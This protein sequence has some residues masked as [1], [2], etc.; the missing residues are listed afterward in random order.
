MKP[1]VQL[2]PV[3]LG[4]A[5][6]RFATLH[7]AEF[8]IKNKIGIGA[9]V[10]LIRS[11]DVIP[12][13]QKVIKPAREGKMPDEGYNYQWNATHKD[14]VLV[15]AAQNS[16][17]QMKIIEDF[18]Q[19]IRCNWSRKRKCKENNGRGF[20]YYSKNIKSFYRRLET[21]QGFKIKNCYKN[22]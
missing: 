20:R 5:E 11:G 21:V 16:T 2:Q 3:E 12:K 15:D 8:V 14:L 10:Q 17:V 7:N 13:V 9:V 6:I 18:L 22:S 19:E 4:G 1:K